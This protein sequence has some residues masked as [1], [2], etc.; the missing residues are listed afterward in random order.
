MFVGHQRKVNNLSDGIAKEK[1]EQKE[2][3]YCGDEFEK[4]GVR[5]V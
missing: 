3:W 1:S 5:R 4:E 2:K